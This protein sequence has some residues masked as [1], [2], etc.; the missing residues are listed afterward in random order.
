MTRIIL[1]LVI[2]C[3]LLSFTPPEW[4]SYRN[5]DGMFKVLTRGAFQQ[6]TIK[7]QTTIGEIT[8]KTFIYQPEEQEENLVYM[9][10]YYD[11]PKGSIHSDSTELL[12]DFFKNTIEQSAESVNGKVIYTNELEQQG[13]RAWQW[14]VNYQ[15]GKVAIRTR[16]FLINNRFYSIQTVGLTDAPSNNTADFFM[17]SL[18]ILGLEEKY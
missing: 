1:G 18:K 8:T 6:K 11:F 17:N 13:Y 12:K 15:E 14:R 2:S 5:I 7:A 3:T 9:I 16:S 4:K 10:T